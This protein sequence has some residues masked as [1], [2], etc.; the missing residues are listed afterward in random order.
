MSDSLGTALP[1]EIAGKHLLQCD[2]C[3]TY[4][5]SDDPLSD[6]YFIECGDCREENNE[7]T[8]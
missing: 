6:D 8:G 4:C 2:T 3:G 7:R 5:Y 1:K